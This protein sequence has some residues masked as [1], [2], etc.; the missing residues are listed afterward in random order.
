M[1][2]LLEKC[3][4]RRRA[5][6]L[7]EVN[8]EIID[9]S[10]NYI[11]NQYKKAIWLDSALK[12]CEWDLAEAP[13]GNADLLRRV[14]FF[15]WTEAVSDFD[16][17]I[18][19]AFQSYYKA[20]IDHIR[21]G[22]ELV[23]V[24]SFFNS[25]IADEEQAR[26]WLRSERGTPHFNRALE[27]LTKMPRF[28]ALEEEIQWS[29]SLKSFYYK[30]CDIVHVKGVEAS[31]QKLQ[32]SY[33]NYS[34]IR[35][36]AF[37]ALSLEQILDTFIEAVRFCATL[38]ALSNPTLL[39]GLPLDEKFGLNGPMSGF[40]CHAQAERLRSLLSIG[41]ESYFRRL[42][43]IDDEV[44]SLV[45]WV[46]NFPDISQSELELQ[47]EGFNRLLS[48]VEPSSDEPKHDIG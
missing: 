10:V 28:S 17:S 27:K 12:F 2:L 40:F 41:T 21:R 25:S 7:K 44:L 42:I 13:L 39:V 26:D 33:A 30:L 29:D 43:E 46:Q 1:K 20:S 5:T 15:P 23:L 48:P 31:F 36:P 3:P 37:V 34:G 45:R 8:A 14:G 32:P 18:T 11:N 38:L 22:L 47:V 9:A 35:A 4:Y 6:L 19:L 16:T 24:G